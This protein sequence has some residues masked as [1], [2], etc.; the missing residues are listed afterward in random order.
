MYV[1]TVVYAN[2]QGPKPAP[3]YAAPAPATIIALNSRRCGSRMREASA[4]KTSATTTGDTRSTMPIEATRFGII[5]FLVDTR[6]S[7][8]ETSYA[9]GARCATRSRQRQRVGAGDQLLCVMGVF[10]SL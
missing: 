8:R 4:I 1:A 3:R 2:S 5:W 7:P 9:T 10:A 6:L